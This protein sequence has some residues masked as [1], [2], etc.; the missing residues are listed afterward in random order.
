MNTNRRQDTAD[1]VSSL[2]A[3][4]VRHRLAFAASCCERMLPNYLAFS[5]CTGWGEVKRLRH[6][7]DHIW[8][9]VQGRE[10]ETAKV[11][12]LAATALENAPDTERFNCFLTSQATDA[13]T[14]IYLAL[15]SCLSRNVNDIAEISRLSLDSIDMYLL[16]VNEPNVTDKQTSPSLW[17]MIEDLPLHKMERKRQFDDLELLESNRDLTLELAAAMRESSKAL[18]IQPIERGLVSC[19]MIDS[20]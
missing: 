2:T 11:S 5:M 7:L 4:Q 13:A 3:M 12:E 16:T 9:L 19:S 17:G 8:D 20:R 10:M 6:C 14:A 1:V 18:G 15:Q